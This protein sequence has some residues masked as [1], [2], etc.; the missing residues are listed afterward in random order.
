MISEDPIE[1]FE[2]LDKHFFAVKFSN[3]EKTTVYEIKNGD[4]IEK[5]SLPSIDFGGYNN[6]ASFY[7]FSENGKTGLFDSEFNVVVS[8]GD[9]KKFDCNADGCFFKY[10]DG[11]FGAFTSEKGM[12]TLKSN[13]SLYFDRG[14]PFLFNPDKMI[15]VSISGTPI[16]EDE[17]G[18]E[19]QPVYDLEA[20]T[21]MRDI[22]IKKKVGRTGNQILVN[23]KGETL[24]LTSYFCLLY[25]SPSPRDATLSR[26][27]S[28]A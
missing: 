22:F 13:D 23:S 5:L 21:W 10:P 8:P 14:L 2:I 27:P 20:G 28:S 1:T 24:T 26:M 25:T 6:N 17:E 4:V 11:T 7:A 3:I 9:Y 15:P 12:V 16:F 18:I 19:Y